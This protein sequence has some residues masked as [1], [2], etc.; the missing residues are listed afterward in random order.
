MIGLLQVC[1]PTGWI[2]G[3]WQSC[4]FGPTT[5]LIGEGVWGL[6]IGAGLWTALYLAGGGSSTTPT[7]VTI[8]LASILFPTLPAAYSGIAWSI[9]VVGAVGAAMQ[10]LQKYFLSEGTI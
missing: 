8:I 5:S 3:D 6:L 10:A 1:K 9:L 4:L 2:N 7:V